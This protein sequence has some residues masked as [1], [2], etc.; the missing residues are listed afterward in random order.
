MQLHF[1]CS[2]ELAEDHLG[3]DVLDRLVE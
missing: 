2:T 1:A 3:L